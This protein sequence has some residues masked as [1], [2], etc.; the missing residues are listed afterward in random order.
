MAFHRRQVL[1]LVATAAAL[2][3]VPCLA[4]A[5][6][7]PSRP[8]HW[9]VGFTPGGASD[10]FARL[11][12]Q[13]LSDR[14]GQQFIIEN[15]PGAGTNIATETVIRAAPNGYT[16]LLC[17]PANAINATLYDRLNF[18]FIRDIA[19]VATLARAPN[20]MLV[21]P[22]FPGKTVPEFIAYAKANPKNVSMASS[23]VGASSHLSGE[24][25][26]ML[27]G[28]EMVH[29]PY[30]GAPQAITDILSG[31]VQVMFSTVPP[32]IEYVQAGRL[33]ALAV[34]TA[35]RLEVLP[36]VPSVSEFVPGYESSA[37]W[38]VGAPRN[39]PTSV[40]HK[41]NEEINTALSDSRMK[42]RFLDLG[43]TPLI[44]SPADFGRFIADETE[45]WGKVARFAGLKPE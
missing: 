2:P 43:V 4:L 5:Q 44:G 11:V 22:A 34:T 14:L 27:A 37:W 10:I 30:R 33:R 25:F 24:L 39:T 29:V 7:Y 23:G 19:P 35:G 20:V 32:A 17:S 9:I 16:L 42:A 45:K 38:G 12:G 15:R 41:L 3:T 40:A 1:Q 13:W 28:I 31:Q 18:N 21:N 26:K 36:D 6:P 8:V